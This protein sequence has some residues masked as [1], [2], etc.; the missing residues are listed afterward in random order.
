MAQLAA[1]TCDNAEAQFYTKGLLQHSQCVAATSGTCDGV[2]EVVS[3]CTGGTV[4]GTASHA[5]GLAP[6]GVMLAA[7]PLLQTIA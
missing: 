6:A 3:E 4:D 5:V 7:L 1:A 2:T